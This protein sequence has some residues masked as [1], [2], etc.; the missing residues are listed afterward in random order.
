MK[1]LFEVRVSMKIH[2]ESAQE[3]LTAA[4]N[5]SSDTVEVEEI[6]LKRV[7]NE[8]AAPCAE[9]TDVLA[10]PGSGTPTTPATLARNLVTLWE[11]DN[12]R[13]KEYLSSTGLQGTTVTDLI[14]E[15][16]RMRTA[17]LERLARLLDVSPEALVTEG[18]C[19]R[20]YVDRYPKSDV[21]LTEV[22]ANNMIDCRRAAG[23][24]AAELEH[25]CGTKSAVGRLEDG[26]CVSIGLCRV[27]RI[28]KELGVRAADLFSYRPERKTCLADQTCGNTELP[29]VQQT[30]K[31]AAE[32]RETEPE[33]TSR[34]PEEEQAL[35]V[36]IMTADE[37][38]GDNVA[39]IRSWRNTTQR[40]FAQYAGVSQ[41]LICQL[42]AGVHGTSLKKLDAIAKA[43]GVK[44][45]VLLTQQAPKA[46]FTDTANVYPQFL[47]IAGLLAQNLSRIRSKAG[48]SMTALARKAEVSPAQICNIEH[49]RENVQLATIDKLAKALGITAAV[50]LEVTNEQ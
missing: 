15:A 14:G 39:R 19:S 40:L 16:Y 45:S 33:Q 8:P 48:V 11:Q 12:G 3:A 10:V 46:C 50:L 5:C 18:A 22:L 13:L 34:E 26:T 38:L 32:P 47:D 41:W 21:S 42:E 25:R 17:D 7:L 2:A 36:R 28:A 24:N 29:C 6:S 44:P 20:V 37:I 49:R 31:P 9:E 27:D 43:V 23:I 35:P 4:G 30:C 1:K